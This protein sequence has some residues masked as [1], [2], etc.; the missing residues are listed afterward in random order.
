[1]THQTWEELMERPIHR[2]VDLIDQRSQQIYNMELEEARGLLLRDDATSLTQL[3]GSFALTAREG[4]VIR[5]ARSLDRPMRYFL[6]KQE[7]GPLLV[8]ADR[9]DEIQEFLVTQGYG[10]QFHPSYTRMVPAHHVTSIRLIGCPDPNPIYQRFLEPSAE[11]LQAD[12]D[13]IGERYVAALLQAL[14]SWLQVVPPREP[15]GVLFSGGLDSGS[16]LLCLYKLLLARGQS[17]S[18]LKAFT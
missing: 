14:D 10:D 3:L 7:S 6:A 1:M 16:V 12:L 2:V 18:R 15:I 8:V 11:S 9:I 5:M 17:P 4:E 13:L